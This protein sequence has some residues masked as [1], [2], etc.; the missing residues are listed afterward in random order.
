MIADHDYHTTDCLIS[1]ERSSMM[2]VN[3]LAGQNS[4]MP[5]ELRKVGIVGAAGWRVGTSDWTWAAAIGTACSYINIQ[6]DE[7]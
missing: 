6:L 4:Q 2:G 3:S 1:N 7:V 5:Q